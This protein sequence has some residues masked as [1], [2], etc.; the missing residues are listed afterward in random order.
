[1]ALGEVGGGGGGGSEGK[2]RVLRSLGIAAS[3]ISLLSKEG[4]CGN[5]ILPCKR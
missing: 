3:P 4:V 2:V 1:M 5:E